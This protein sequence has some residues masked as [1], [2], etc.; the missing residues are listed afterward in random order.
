MLILKL[1]ALLKP[2]IAMNLKLSHQ[3]S[4]HKFPSYK[5][6][7]ISKENDNSSRKDSS[8]GQCYTSVVTY[9][10]QKEKEYKRSKND[11]RK[12]S[13]PKSQRGAATALGNAPITDSTAPLLSLNKA[14][15][16]SE[17]LH[18]TSNLVKLLKDIYTIG[19][20]S[21]AII[22]PVKAPVNKTKP[23]EHTYCQT[24]E[25]IIETSFDPDNSNA[26][27]EEPP[28]IP[29]A[30]YSTIS[31]RE[32]MIT[33][34]NTPEIENSALS[35]SLEKTHIVPETP[36]T[37]PE[38][39]LR[40]T[41]DLDTSR[42]QRKAIAVSRNTL[43]INNANSPSSLSGTKKKTKK[44]SYSQAESISETSR[45]LDPQNV[46]PE[47]PSQIPQTVNNLRSQR[48]AIVAPRNTPVREKASPPSSLC[49]IPSAPEPHNAT[50]EREII[51]ASGNAPVIDSDALPSSLG[52]TP[53][54]SETHNVSS[55]EPLQIP[56]AFVTSKS[57]RGAITVSGNSPVIVKATLPSSLIEIPI[58]PKPPNAIEKTL[59]I[60]QALDTSRSQRKPIIAPKS[61]L[62][63]NTPP[64]LVSEVSSGLDLP[65][66]TPEEPLRIPQAFDTLGSHG[67]AIKASGNA[68]VIGNPAPSSS[69]W[70]I[71]NCPEPSNS[72]PKEPLQ[73][74][75]NFRS[76]AGTIIAPEKTPVVDNAA[77][78][79]SLTGDK[80]KKHTHSQFESVPK[81]VSG[82]DSS[83]VTPKEPPQ[84]PQDT[85]RS[86]RGTIIAP[87][88]IPV[89]DNASPTSSLTGEKKKKHT[90][91]QIESVPE[92]VS[93]T[94]P[95]NAKSEEP[96]QIPQSM[97]TSRSHRGTIIARVKTSGMDNAA[98]SLSPA[99]DKKKKHEHSQIKSAAKTISGPEPPSVTPE[100]PPQI[101][102]AINTFKSQKRTIIA[103]EK[104]QVVDNATPPS[105]LEP[106]NTS[107]EKSLKIPQPPTAPKS[108]RGAATALG[109]APITDSTA[110][111][112][113]LNKA[114]NLSETLHATSN[115]VK[116][117]KDIYTIGSQSGAIITPVKAP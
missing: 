74:Q 34:G 84:I 44:H 85:S 101:P 88:E 95:P 105:V 11:I 39:P 76:K 37:I 61:S 2:L 45:N 36:N 117:L 87:E 72:T 23:K 104:T 18:A 93:S 1:T 21:G 81:T 56:K 48:G 25:S 9:R 41:Q 46:S 65:N 63:H 71:P 102:Q 10:R 13:T 12:C 59:H 99:G 51:T 82:P 108:Q 92:T 29:P 26:T 78:P 114:S 62:I 68:L 67:E 107:L 47:E 28:Q 33:S 89:M 3:N 66:A 70:E 83:N 97:D 32:A 96:P 115:L 7:Q 53:S 80:K 15:N 54:D 24:T 5:Y 17:T 69:V 77:P 98:P 94:E 79:S 6:F 75:D 109:N 113:S 57:Q 4:L 20:Q 8:S 31:Q 111:L 30:L 64:P 60:P 90:H 27:P 55:E 42:S 19:S 22:T 16:L 110:P 35:S 49:E 116:L 50:S 91:S 112:L 106:K 52:E 103:P 40:I 73:I 58:V 38:E 86:Q 14:S 43:V 100:Q